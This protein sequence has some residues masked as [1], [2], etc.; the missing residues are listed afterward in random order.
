MNG[1]LGTESGRSVSS[2]GLWLVAL[3]FPKG[4]PGVPSSALTGR[5]EAVWGYPA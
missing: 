4:R 3:V 1:M 5:T 2:K